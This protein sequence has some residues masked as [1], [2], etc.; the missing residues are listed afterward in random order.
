MFKPL[1]NDRAKGLAYMHKMKVAH[2]DVH[3]RNVLFRRRR[4]T[5]TMGTNATNGTARAEDYEVN[6]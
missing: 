5:G 4:R 1:T 6:T 3:A 2:H